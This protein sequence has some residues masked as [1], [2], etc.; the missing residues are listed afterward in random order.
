MGRTDLVQ[1]A[2]FATEGVQ[3]YDESSANDGRIKN[4][5]KNEENRRFSTLFP[6][7]LHKKHYRGT[8][9][10]NAPVV[11]YSVLPKCDSPIAVEYLVAALG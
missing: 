8:A 2:S 1:K 5:N 10:N 7:D 3:W 11:F 4:I 9:L 6:L